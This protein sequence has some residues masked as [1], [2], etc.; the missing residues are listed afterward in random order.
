M[1][2]GEVIPAHVQ[3]HKAGAVLHRDLCG[4]ST[5]FLSGSDQ[6]GDLWPVLDFQ[7]HPLHSPN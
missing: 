3:L 4:H 2:G 5:H 6:T 1:G 7:Q